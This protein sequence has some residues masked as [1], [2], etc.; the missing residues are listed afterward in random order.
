MQRDTLKTPNEKGIL[1]NVQETKERTKNKNP[2]IREPIR[3]KNKRKF[4]HNI[5]II[6]LNGLNIQIK[7]TTGIC[8]LN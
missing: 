8:R 2:K 6:V 7:T 5:S 1:N 3:N 4:I